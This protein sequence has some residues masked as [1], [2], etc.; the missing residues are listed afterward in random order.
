MAWL[1]TA[2]LGPGGDAGSVHV[3]DSWQFD[4]HGA[5]QRVVVR[6]GRP[7]QQQRGGTAIYMVLGL[8]GGFIGWSLA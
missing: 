6:L 8:M 1:S 3:H 5:W 7:E 2:W 4:T